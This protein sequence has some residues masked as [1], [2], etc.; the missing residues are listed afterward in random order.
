M[1]K[2]SYTN[3]LTTTLGI[4]PFYAMYSSNPYNQINPNPVAKPLAPSYCSR[5][6]GCKDT[7]YTN[8]NINV[9]IGEIALNQQSA[10]QASEKIFE[11]A[12]CK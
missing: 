7:V 11:R 10:R 8:V 1:V 6:C 9:C 4:T 2:L 12:V 5:I 3:T